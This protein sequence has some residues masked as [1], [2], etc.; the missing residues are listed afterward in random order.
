MVRYKLDRKNL[1]HCVTAHVAALVDNRKMP[2]FPKK[3]GESDSESDSSSSDEDRGD[4]DD[5][6]PDPTYVE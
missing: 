4:D 3:K 5:S 2:L 1:A 6:L